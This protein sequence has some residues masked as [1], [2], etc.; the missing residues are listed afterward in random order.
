MEEEP[1]ILTQEEPNSADAG[2]SHVT[3]S[4]AHSDPL[5][6]KQQLDLSARRMRAAASRM[7]D[8]LKLLAHISYSKVPQLHNVVGYLET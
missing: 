5:T 7:A 8:L 2:S 4:E 3:D 6:K 1:E